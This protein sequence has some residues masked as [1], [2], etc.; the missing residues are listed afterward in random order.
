M[1]CDETRPLLA[2]YVSGAMPKQDRERIADHL[3]GCPACRSECESLR[4]V[5]RLLDDCAA[6]TVQVDVAALY[7][8]TLRREKLRA[9]RWRRLALATA[10]A[11]GILLLVALIPLLRKGTEP[12]P[13]DVTPVI[14]HHHP[15]PVN[16][17][18]L[19]RLEELTQALAL[20]IQSLQVKQQGEQTQLANQLARMREELQRMQAVTDADMTTLTRHIDT[21]LKGK[22]ET[23]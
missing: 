3:A 2:E 8:E 13:R 11:A 5:Y 9:R 14:V 22:G 23:P 12:D 21:I 17:D 15:P 1:T 4:G 6:P 20:D 16:N 7:R 18:R 19:Q 10:L